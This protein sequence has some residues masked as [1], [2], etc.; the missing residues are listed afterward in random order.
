MPKILIVDDEAPI[1]DVLSYN[2][3]RAHYDVL[4]A[5][6]GEQALAVARRELP[7]L[8]ILD[9]MLPKLDGIEVCRARCA[10]TAT[11]RSS[12]SPPATKRSTGWWALSWAP[13]ITWSSPSACA[14]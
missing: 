1:I 8:I 13:T 14:S 3:K 6:D 11:C 5:W 4:V 7:D 9:L 12:C 10:A 2:L